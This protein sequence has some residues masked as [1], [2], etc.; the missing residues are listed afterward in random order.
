MNKE[1]KVFVAGAKGLRDER[2]AL[3]YLPIQKMSK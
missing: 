3:K 1:I 2:N